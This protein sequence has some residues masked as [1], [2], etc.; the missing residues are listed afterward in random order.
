MIKYCVCGRP[1]PHDKG[2]HCEKPRV[3]PTNGSAQKPEPV[4]PVVPTYGTYILD[5]P[6][7]LGH[8]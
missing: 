7:T 3:R 6:M 1:L 8:D 4:S 2:P 5:Y